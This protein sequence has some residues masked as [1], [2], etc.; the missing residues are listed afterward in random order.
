MYDIQF[1]IS[2]HVNKE[3]E[4]VI[5]EVSETWH[6]NPRLEAVREDRCGVASEADNHRPNPTL[7]QIDRRRPRED[8][9]A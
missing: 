9:P 5:F 4:Q 3:H 8:L 1:G 6:W 7:I 2:E